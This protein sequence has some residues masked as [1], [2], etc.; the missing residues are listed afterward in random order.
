MGLDAGPRFYRSFETQKEVFERVLTA[1]ARAGDKV[2]T[3]HSV[4]SAKAVLD[5]IEQHLPPQQGT[6]VMHWFTGSA[7]EARRAVDMGCYFSV[8]HEMLAN[9]KHAALVKNLPLDRLLTETDGPFT[10]LGERP[11]KPSDV[12][13]AISK[14]A[15]LL[16]RSEDV[17]AELLIANLK[18]L[19]SLRT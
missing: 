7:S 10:A 6:A 18:R 2:L 8:N 11:A 16:E 13:T 5:M 14:L 9:P 1:C 4:R 12:R 3:I 19:L 17:V 15:L